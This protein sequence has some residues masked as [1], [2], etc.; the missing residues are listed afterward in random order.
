MEEGVNSSYL[1]RFE[2]F[3]VNLRSGELYKNREKLKLPEQSFQILTMLLKRPG[4]V[5]LRHE[6]QK[7][8][9]PNDTVVE[10]ESS[11]NSAIKKLRLALG[12][13]AEKPRYIETLA[14]RGYRW[15]V[16]VEWADVPLAKPPAHSPAP[17]TQGQPHYLIG[18]K[19]SHYRVLE[20]IGGGGM[21]VVYKAED[22]KL[23]RRVALKFLPEELADDRAAMERFQREARAASALNHLNICTI[24]EV[25][26]HEGQPFIVMEMLEGQTLRDLVPTECFRA[27]AKKP[28]L[29]LQM[30]LD[31]AIQ[32]AHGL[33]AAHERGIIHRDIKPA[34]IF[35]TTHGQVKILDFGLAKL[36]E[37]ETADS[38]PEHLQQELAQECNSNLTLSRTGTT[39]GTAGYMSPEQIRGEKLDARTDLFSFG[40][41]LYEVA[42]GQ[43]A[44]AGETVP[45]LRE[46]ILN[47]TPTPVRRLNIDV[48]PRLEAIINRALEKD[49]QARYQTASQM[50][51]DLEN[52][53]RARQSRRS[54]AVLWVLV[55]AI[56]ALLVAL[57]TAFW[58]TKRQSPSPL[59]IKQRQL[60]VNSSENG[61]TGG[62]ISPDGELLA[63]ADIQGI[64]VQSLGTGKVR[65]VPEPVALR[66][67]QVDWN[68]VP[69][70]FRDS[71]RFLANAMP[72][73]DSPSI[74]VVGVDGVPPQKLRDDA[75]AWS[76]SRDSSWIAF[77]ANLNN[78][79]YR[80]LWLMKADGGNPHE[81]FKANGN[82]AFVGA[83]WSP[84]GRR[85]GYVNLYQG[86]DT[87]HLSIETRDLNGGRPITA[88]AV[89]FDLVDWIWLPDGRIITSFPDADDPMGATCDFWQMGVDLHTG[90]PF[91]KPTRMTNWSGFCMDQLSASADARRLTFRR[92]S[93]QSVIYIADL[94][95]K[96][97]GISVP[98]RLTLTE[99]R[100]YP[101]GWTSDSNAVVFVSDRGGRRQIYKQSI[102]SDIAEP[103]STPLGD[104][105]SGEAG[106]ID[107]EVPRISPDGAWVLH[108]I[109]PMEN[110]SSS[111][112][113]LVRIPIS[114]GPPEL[115]LTTSL[116]AAHSVRCAR[117][118]SRLCVLAELTSD[119]NQLVFTAFDVLSGRGQEVARFR[120][121]PSP[122]AEYTWD[123]SPDGKRIAV[124][125]RSEGS[126]HLLLLTGQRP[127]DFP[128]RGWSNLQ[129][130]DWA[131][132]GGSLFISA[133][134][135]K[136]SALLRVDSQS[137]THLLWK[138]SGIAQP[139]SS[140]F[141]GGPSTPWAVPSP[142]GRHLAICTW[143]MNANMWLMENF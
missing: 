34:N 50:R 123:L 121:L 83:E 114:G 24:H 30:L 90:R 127:Q 9:W 120:T 66:G 109:L 108:L 139:S 118:P 19:V 64:H 22:I 142:D 99:G 106:L 25:E 1:A 60:T 98:K 136:G 77:G 89:P 69:T 21:G 110:G 44:F 85:L 35:L 140:P 23:G 87:N 124:L 28:T 97:I 92:S 51:A 82:N 63:Y 112:V 16:P 138:S 47:Q 32:I 131:A 71:R 105:V 58:H 42:A 84:D 3:E 133:I 41:V 96:G 57:G 104:W 48:P 79:Y 27:G 76:L 45:V 49:C 53:R 43:R 73:G 10:F 103:V 40:L 135:K 137:N 62:A 143:N 15:I 125:R 38:P 68:I 107:K 56:C 39:I 117:S 46:A 4:E 78:L 81:L 26:E 113:R 37:S 119:R 54:G 128:V 75:F 6:I 116:G 61:V 134:T 130:V 2:C 29:P 122:D 101:A 36:Q 52:L 59:E 93:T 55:A 18:K 141:M 31:V 33:E 88:I 102:N 5:V 14:R 115:V 86:E 72:H 129:S 132:D 7:K 74:W 95:E 13:S 20:I 8:L 70:W 11:I 94:Q 126:V 91:N 80:E 12:D 100:S 111:P 17:I 67:L 65:D